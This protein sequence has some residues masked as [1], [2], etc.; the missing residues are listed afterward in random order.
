[1][2]QMAIL[3]RD[4]AKKVEANMDYPGQIKIHLIRE[5]RAVDYAK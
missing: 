2:T 1:M 4:I 5:N 3:A